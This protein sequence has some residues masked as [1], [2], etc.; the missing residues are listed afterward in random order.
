MSNSFKDDKED[1]KCT[2]DKLKP[3]DYYF[4]LLARDWANN[5]EILDD[6]SFKI[7]IPVP[8]MDYILIIT[9]IMIVGV[10]GIS[11]LVIYKKNK[12]YLRVLKR[13]EKI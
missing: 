9:S 6:N 12:E 5:V 7:S 2:I 8:I 1:F 3:G 10:V 11:A 4:L 13:F